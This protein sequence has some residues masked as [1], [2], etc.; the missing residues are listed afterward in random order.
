[1]RK[2][3]PITIS[4]INKFLK[5][6]HKPIHQTAGVSLFQMQYNKN[7]KVQYNIDLIN[8]QN[9]IED[10]TLNYSLNVNDK[11]RLT[12]PQNA[13]KKTRYIASL[14]D[15]P[16]ADITNKSII[17]TVVAGFLLKLLLDS[18]LFVL[19]YQQK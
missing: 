14:Y 17:I 8:N 1:M 2:N 10:T 4:K 9:K 18:M 3:K 13:L 12:E 19:I 7:L 15:Y 5:T 6:D 11:V 16:I